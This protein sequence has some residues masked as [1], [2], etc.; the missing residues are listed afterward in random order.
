MDF[1]I[2]IPGIDPAFTQRAKLNTSKPM[3]SGFRRND[4]KVDGFRLSSE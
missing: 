2:V 1:H 4:T 3:D